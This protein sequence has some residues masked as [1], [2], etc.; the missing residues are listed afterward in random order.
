MKLSELVDTVEVPQ[1][2]VA[3]TA[4]DSG[5]RRVRR[6]RAGIVVGAAVLTAGVVATA[7]LAGDGDRDGAPAPPAKSP[8]TA[9][10]SPSQ[11]PTVTAAMKMPGLYTDAAW[12]RIADPAPRIQPTPAN[13]VDL[14]AHP[15]DHAVLAISD[16]EDQAGVLVLGEDGQWR[17]VDGVDLVPVNEV[18]TEPGPALRATSLSPD[19]TKLALPQPDSLVVVDLT[20]GANRRFDVAGPVKPLRASGPTTPTCWWPRRRPRP[21]PWSTSTPGR[22][23]P[24]TS[25]RAPPSRTEGLALDWGNE[26]PMTADPTPMRWSDGT[27]VETL[28][29]NLAGVFPLPP[30]V[31]DDVV[32][33]DNVPIRTGLGLDTYNGLENGIVVVD[34]TTG[35]PLAYQPTT[36]SKGDTTQLLGWDG[37]RVLMALV[38]PKISSI[39]TVVVAWDWRNRTIDPLVVLPVWAVSWGQGWAEADLAN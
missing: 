18:A 6:R 15:L 23:S 7:S 16:P 28:M 2:Q 10:P 13:T 39:Y 21:A 12:E 22:P 31:S 27:T 4:W 26:G 20:T 5:V 24:R 30:L 3:D 17:R 14:T 9:N 37:D 1:T 35:N 11:E 8:S 29:N 25:A 34:R 32:V 38:N 36:R 33:G 19:A